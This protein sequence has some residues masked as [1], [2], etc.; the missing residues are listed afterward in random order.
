MKKKIS[1][2]KLIAVIVSV[3]LLTLVAGDWVLSAVIYENY[4]NQ[5]FES[6]EPLMLYVEDFE[7]LRRTKYEFPS[8]K[9]QMLTGYMYSSGEN[10][11]GIVV[12]AHGFGG[13]GH[14]SYMDCAHYFASNG[15]YVFAYDVTGNDESEGD[16]TNGLPQGIIDLDRAITFVEQSGHFPKLPIVLF[17][18]SWGGY[19]VCSVLQY[20]PEVKSVV[21][22]SGFNDSTDLIEAQGKNMVGDG[23][24]VML[25]FV[26][27]HE[28]IKFGRYASA[29]AMDGFASSDAAVL[30]LHSADDDV[31]PVEYG[32]DIYY[33]K[34]KDDPRFTFIRLEDRGHS[35]VYNDTTYIDEFNAEFAKWGE[36]L[37]YDYEADENKERFAAEK[38]DYIRRNL[39]RDKWC[40]MLDK[41]LFEKF[42]GFYDANL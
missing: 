19:S 20:H 3:V 28:S 35:Y 36:T 16:G 34:Y 18:H 22:C 30:V 24:Y 14:N 41:P 2:K 11:R 6:Y 38:A 13:G 4:F 42:V 33:K 8:D 15:Y 37:D 7:G 9:G 23:I 27:L 29:T 39:D 31:V 5:R 1:K 25:P 10:Q 21:V 32:Y 40:D 26:N 17:G 12:L